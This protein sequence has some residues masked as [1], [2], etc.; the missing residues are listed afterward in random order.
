MCQAHFPT[1][2]SRLLLLL[3]P[4]LSW[5]RGAGNRDERERAAS[6]LLLP[7]PY[8]IIGGN[9]HFRGPALN[10]RQTCGHISDYVQRLHQFIGVLRISLGACIVYVVG[11]ERDKKEEGKTLL[12]QERRGE[13]A[14]KSLSITL[15]PPSL[16]SGWVGGF[17]WWL[18]R[19]A[20][21][22]SVFSSDGLKINSEGRKKGRKQ[23]QQPFEKTLPPYDFNALMWQP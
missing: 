12:G 10:M 20:T 15:L 23:V 19:A 2:Y 13:G 18:V 7:M 21:R 5:E 9:D 6:G 11:C 3:P 16:W 22:L 8:Q 1:I 17:S 4:S 14:H